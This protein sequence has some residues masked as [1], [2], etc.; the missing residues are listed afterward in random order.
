MKGQPP[1]LQ[2]RPD[3]FCRPV[4]PG[5]QKKHLN[6]SSVHFGMVTMAAIKQMEFSRSRLMQQ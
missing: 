1:L 4:K 3:A 5:E 6:S 2:L